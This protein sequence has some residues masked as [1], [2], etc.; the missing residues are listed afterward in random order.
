[1]HRYFVSCEM[2]VKAIGPKLFSGL[3]PTAR[4]FEARSSELL[5]LESVSKACLT[6]GRVGSASS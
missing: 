2:K 1:M 4:C 3:Y 6:G 5:K